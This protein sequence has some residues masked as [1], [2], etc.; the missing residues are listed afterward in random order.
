MIEV[1]GSYGE[2]GGQILRTSVALSALLSK[3]VR[4]YNIRAKRPNPGL[5]PQ[6]LSAIRA[7]AQLCS[8][9]VLGLK[10]GSKEIVFK[11]NEVKSGAVSIDVGT[12]G[13]ITLILQAILPVACL[14]KGKVN[15][16]LKGGTDVKWSPTIEY[17]KRVVL[18]AF[19]LIG[20]NARV[21]VKKRGYYPK[22]G[23]IVVC[24]VEPAKEFKPIN[25]VN[26]EISN[27]R[28]VS[29]CSKLP[30]S[31]A[32]RQAKSA[33]KV[34]REKGIKVES[35]E[36][37]VEPAVAPGT[38]ILVYSVNQ[39]SCYIGGDSIGEIRKRAEDVGKEAALRYLSC[40]EK[41]AVFDV[42]IADMIVT[43]LSLAKG[44]SKFKAEAKSMHLLT[45]LYVS[46]L[47]TGFN[48]SI[49]EL[50]NGS[51]IVSIVNK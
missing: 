3:P 41:G 40:Y 19:S 14:S 18:P 28:I 21:D 39:G 31:V 22:G 17:F 11:P 50:A 13:S 42:H 2:G 25:L 5:R 23:G 36:S 24:E 16:E 7:V 44:E 29:V 8:A 37:K 45:N 48:Y 9:N 33:E 38:S 6:H 32:E 35:T 34:L 49:E 15:L 1:D 12:A 47:F 46:K 30:R 43:L 20:V 4:V 51:V 27:P 26:A 10:E